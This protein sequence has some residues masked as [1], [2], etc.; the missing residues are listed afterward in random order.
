MIS[1]L[2][3][4]P[5]C[6]ASEVGNPPCPKAYWDASRNCFLHL[7][8]IFLL[9]LTYLLALA[10][11]PGAHGH[12]A[13]PLTRWQCFPGVNRSQGGKRQNWALSITAGL[14]SK[15]CS[16]LETKDLPKEEHEK[17]QTRFGLPSLFSHPLPPAR[18]PVAVQLSGESD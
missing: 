14:C 2:F 18:V 6:L 16:S 5:M 10:E 15:A 13:W 17:D 4:A 3:P 9:S 11:F 8:P 7:S 12:L 1:G